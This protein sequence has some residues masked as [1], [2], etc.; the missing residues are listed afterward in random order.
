MCVNIDS[1]FSVFCWTRLEVYCI[2]Y[3]A[4][5][6]LHPLNEIFLLLDFFLCL[7]QLS[8]ESPLVNMVPQ[9]EICGWGLIRYESIVLQLEISLPILKRFDCP[10]NIR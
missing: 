9:T 10:N 8:V 1:C 6:C 5:L 3:F 7:A 2:I 4:Y